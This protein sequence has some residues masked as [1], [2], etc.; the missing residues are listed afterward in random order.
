MLLCVNLL[1]RAGEVIYISA[2]EVEDSWEWGFFQLSE[3]VLGVLDHG[4]IQIESATTK[5]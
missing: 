3:Y 1:V 5:A 4:G 2:V